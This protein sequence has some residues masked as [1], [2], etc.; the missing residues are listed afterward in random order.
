MTKQERC[1]IYVNWLYFNP[2][3]GFDHGIH[4]FSNSALKLWTLWDTTKDK[5]IQ[6]RTEK[7]EKRGKRKTAYTKCSSTGDIS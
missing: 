4:Q 3:H 5:G 7:S 2:Y 6:K 1:D